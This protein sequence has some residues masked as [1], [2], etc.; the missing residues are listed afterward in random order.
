M[1]IENYWGVQKRWVQPNY[2]EQ[3][4]LATAEQYENIKD[5]FFKFNP[6]SDYCWATF[7][8]FVQMNFDLVPLCKAMLLSIFYAESSIS[9]KINLLWETLVF[10]EKLE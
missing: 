3:N 7:D 5:D 6:Q 4:S 10:F 1:H 2:V 8:K 9:D